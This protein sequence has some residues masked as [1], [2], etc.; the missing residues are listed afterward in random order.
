MVSEASDEI[1]EIAIIGMAGRFPGAR[2]VAEFWDNL[3][4]GVE[5]IRFYTKE[6]LAEAGIDPAVLE[7]PAYVRASGYLEDA[8]LFDSAFFG[9]SAEEAEVIDPQHRL[10]LE[11]AWTALDSAGY[12]A[13]T[14]AGSIGIVGGMSTPMYLLRNLLWNRR[15]RAEVS[16]IELRVRNGKDFLTSVAAYKLGLTGP[17]FTVQ[18]ACSTSL[19][20]VGVACQILTSLQ[21]DMALAGGVSVGSPLKSGFRE[22]GELFAADGH[23][24]AFDAA[25]TGTP[26]GSGVGVVVLKRLADALADGDHVRAVIRGFAL[27]NDGAQKIGYAAPSIEGQAE[28]VAMAQAVAGVRPETLGFIE[29][30]G[31]GTPLG[32][33]IEVRALTHAFRASTDDKGFCAI[34][35]VKTNVGHLDAAAGVTSLIKTVL[36]LEHGKVPPSLNFRQPNPNIDFANSPFFVNT[37]LIDWPRVVGRRRAGVSAFAVGGMNA[38]LVLEEAPP[39]EPS[40]PETTPQLL[41]LSAKTET[42]LEKV[43]DRVVDFLRS[44]PDASFSDVAYTLQVGR[45]ALARRRALVCA[46]REDAI[47]ALVAR[48]PKRVLTA[49]R[50]AQNRPVFFLFPGLGEQYPNMGLELYQEDPV[51]RREIDRC[52]ELLAPHLG[53]DLRSVLYPQGTVTAPERRMEAGT[54]GIDLRKLLASRRQPAAEREIDHTLLAQ[55]AMFAVEYALARVW[56]ELGV[57]PRGLLGFSLGE[58]VAA[59]LAGVLSLEDALRLVVERARIVSGLPRGAMLAVSL[60]EEKVLP[61]LGPRLSVAA[62][63]GAASSVLAGPLEEIADAERELTARGVT[64]LRL[65]TSHAFHSRRMEPVRQAV[66]GLLRQIDLKPPGI[67]FLSNVTGTWIEAA[68]AT[69]PEYWGDHLVGTVQFADNLAELWKEP[70]GILVEVGPGQTLSALAL[71]HPA[72]QAGNGAVVVS[73]LRAE[74]DLRPDRALLLD[75]LAR[76]WLAG[77]GIRWTQLH[78]R[79]RR[80]RIEL[81]TYPFERRRCWIEPEPDNAANAAAVEPQ[82]PLQAAVWVRSARAT[83]PP[84]REPVTWLFLTDSGELGARLAARLR[85]GGDLVRE[86]LAADAFRRSKGGHYTVDPEN[87][88]SFAALLADML[89]DASLPSR[90]VHLWSLSAPAAEARAP[91]LGALSALSGG[92]AKLDAR[93]TLRVDCL[94]AGTQS[95][96]G[97]E[98]QEPAKATLLAVCEPGAGPTNLD[99]R[100]IDLVLAEPGTWK[101]ELLLDQLEA[102]LFAGGPEREVALRGKDRWVRELRPLASDG[103]PAAQPRHGRTFLFSGGVGG[104]AGVLAHALAEPGVR[105]AVVEVAGDGRALESIARRGAEVE[106]I[107]AG[108]GD[109]A[110]ALAQLQSRSPLA[111]VVH[112]TI[113]GTAGE[114]PDTACGAEAARLAALG[115]AVGGQ[116]LDLCLVVSDLAAGAECLGRAAAR[117]LA[118]CFAARQDAREP[119][120]WQSLAWRAPLKGEPDEGALALARQVLAAG[121][122]TELEVVAP[123]VP[124]APAVRAEAPAPPARAAATPRPEARFE[125]GSRSPDAAPW[126]LPANRPL[127]RRPDLSHPHVAPSSELEARV[128]E[129]WE[130]IL[131]LS[132]LGVHD[133][134]FALGGDSMLG[135]RLLLKLRETTGV[136]LSLRSL[137]QAPTI[138]EMAELIQKIQRGGEAAEAPALDL[139]AEAVVD[140]AIVAADGQVVEPGEARAVFLTGATGFLGAFLAVELAT[141]TNADVFCLVRAG[142]PDEGTQRIRRNLERYGIWD[143]A[144]AQRIVAVPGDLG[145]PLLGIPEAEFDRLA[146]N[147]DA[148]YHCGAWVNATYAYEL[149]KPANVL[150]TQ[151]ALRLAA[152]GRTKPL[153]FVSTLAVFSHSPMASGIYE[154]AELPAGDELLNGYVQS[155]W[156]AEKLVVLA[157]E[158]GIPTTIFRPPAIGGHSRSGIGNR[159]DFVWNVVKGCI[160]LGAGFEGIQAI[161]VAPV[162][163]VSSA[164][165]HITRHADSFGKAFHLANPVQ[166]TWRELFQMLRGMGYALAPLPYDLWYERL[167]EAARPE[168]DQ[169]LIPF[170]PVITAL[171]VVQARTHSAPILEHLDDTNTRRGLA[172]SGIHCP[173]MSAELVERYVSAFAEQGFFPPPPVGA[174][175]RRGYNL[176]EVA[177]NASTF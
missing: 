98:D 95:V 24:R 26:A 113:G 47:R 104:A 78:A 105:L 93:R 115:S 82:S 122:W 75:S 50:T 19:V 120:R 166:S 94:L 69:D 89:V 52:S 63:S 77:G 2:S 175:A 138:A 88:E 31:T 45:R 64:C 60:S 153:H 57:E 84:R 4:R 142:S 100:A 3:A 101:E 155:K 72:S 177:G 146:A 176:H 28:V 154:D 106:V 33:P 40:G 56:L 35:S 99:C 114:D 87:P 81:P 156:V 70:G 116:P 165:V 29:A 164:I 141:R 36:A 34:G 137:F 161:N 21:C 8:D 107:R 125:I 59:C 143:D 90:A 91:G 134:Y 74:E 51:F 124:A 58:H 23:C 44:R 6:E 86:V 9:F 136:E 173:P 92:L 5:S 54:G 163:Y 135:P 37:R 127:R 7:H 79:A 62:A 67:P 22:H 53:S 49:G 1:D 39:Q 152:R 151:E 15:V 162:D 133:D 123:P 119:V 167:L 139:A 80:R 97:T 30:H 46:D 85:A 96:L 73:S 109:L 10:F 12:D 14:C 172:G 65:R 38:H 132:N 103:G 118:R 160:Q 144:F 108:D 43:T 27:N 25:A 13:A 171:R 66:V 111:G 42:A 168:K 170:L 16:G 110:A 48:D 126:T 158:R 55:P 41:V 131:G 148:V 76:L 149:L 117:R 147:L 174:G 145:Q 11:T 129:A 71:Q 32:D 169:A 61:S 17:S 159:L 68:Q 128:A 140:P 150:G 18:S 121:D 130:Q 157:R 83:R 112:R 102:E 20:A